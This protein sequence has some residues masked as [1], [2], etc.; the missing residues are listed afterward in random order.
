M[1]FNVGDKVRHHLFGDGIVEN[2][3]CAKLP[4][5]VRFSSYIGV[6]YFTKDGRTHKKYNPTLKKV[7]L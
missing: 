7:C 3:T 2:D 6:K 1:N 4:L 5:R